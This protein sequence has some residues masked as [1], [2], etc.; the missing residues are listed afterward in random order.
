MILRVLLFLCIDIPLALLMGFCRAV[1]ARPMVQHVWDTGLDV[2]A[3][4]MATIL[5]HPSVQHAAAPCIAEGL[6]VFLSHTERVEQHVRA[7][8]VTVR[9]TQPEWAR[10]QGQDFPLLLSSFF[11]GMVANMGQQQQQEQRNGTTRTTTTATSSSRDKGETTAMVMLN[12][13]TAVPNETDDDGDD[14]SSTE[15]KLDE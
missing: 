7:L 8:T 1:A 6:H 5:S 12:V 4:T 15:C 9:T 2:C 11:Q 10:Q 13:A 3:H 14:H